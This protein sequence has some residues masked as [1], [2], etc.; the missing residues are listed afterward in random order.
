ML[1]FLRELIDRS[2]EGF[3]ES[4][5]EK[6]NI[7]GVVNLVNTILKADYYVRIDSYTR[8]RTIRRHSTNCIYYEGP[9]ITNTSILRT[10]LAKE[11][12][13]KERRIY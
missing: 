12:R 6:E 3:I 8:E 7:Q 9:A 2:Y 1:K 11:F 5:V 4:N 13:K 10:H